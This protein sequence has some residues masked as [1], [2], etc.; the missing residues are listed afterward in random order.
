MRA[1]CLKCNAKILTETGPLCTICEAA[2]R[3]REGEIMTAV[4]T[5]EREVERLRALG[6]TRDNFAKALKRM[7][8]ED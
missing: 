7:L 1:R 3:E 2:R 6:W 5:I 4:R 8:G